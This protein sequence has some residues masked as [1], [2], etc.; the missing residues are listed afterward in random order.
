M[1]DSQETIRK[2][3]KK[4][5]ELMLEQLKKIPVLQVVCEKT[6]VGRSSYYRWRKADAKF[7]AAA[8]AAINE[9]CQFVSDMA[10]SALISSIRDGNMAGIIFWLK[11]HHPAYNTTRIEIRQGANE[12]DE[13]L[14][15]RQE[16]IL[17]QA[18]SSSEYKKMLNPPETSGSE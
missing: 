9:G 14:T 8:D 17:K 2:R 6:G 12:Q 15:K 18:L 1:N 7:A 16:D 10:E 11:N 4:D 3:I 5:K 13:K